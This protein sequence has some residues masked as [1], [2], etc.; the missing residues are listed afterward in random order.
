MCGRVLEVWKAVGVV[1]EC[2]SYGRVLEMWKDVRVGRVLK[3]R[4]S[5]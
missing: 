5:I 3:L 4:K 2:W 1:E